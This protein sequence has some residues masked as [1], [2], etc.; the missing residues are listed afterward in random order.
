MPLTHTRRFPI[1]HYECDLYGQVN[2]SNYVRYMQE[3]AFDASAAAGYPLARYATMDRYWLVHDT[4]VE[5]LGP[6]R[7]G[8]AVEVTT[9][10][11]DFKHVRSLRAYELRKADSGELVAR[12]HTDW[13]FMN[14]VTGRPA[15]IPPEMAAAFSPEGVAR[16]EPFPSAPRPP[17]GLFKVQRRVEWRDLDPGQHVNNAAYLSYIEDCGVQAAEAHG[18]PVARV[19]TVARRQRIEYLQQAVLGDELELA[20]WLADVEHSSAVRHVAIARISDGELVA[21]AY[22]L[23]EWVEAATGQL[24]RVPAALIGGFASE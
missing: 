4:E 12:G 19:A 1:R 7:Y 23:W 2:P 22:A 10:V 20:T 21:R 24:T 5:Y 6:L 14:T 17:S 16:R 8:D 15:P 11:V 3:T 9:W 18:W 13:V